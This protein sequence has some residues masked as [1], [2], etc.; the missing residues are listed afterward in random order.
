[1]L[2]EYCARYGVRSCFRHLCYLSDLLEH[3]ERGAMIDPTLIHY[4]FAFCSSHVHGHSAGAPP[5]G[6]VAF[7][8]RSDHGTVTVEERDLYASIKDRLRALLEYQIT[9]FRYCFP[10]GRPDGSLKATLSLLERVLMKDVLT[11]ASPDETRAVMK[12]CLENAALVN[13]TRLSDVAKIDEIAANA[14]MHP[15]DKLP[16]LVRLAE[17][18]VEL[19]QENNDHTE[20]FAWFSD[21][22]VEHCEIFWSLFAVDMDAIL[23]IQ[24]PDTWCSFPLFQVLN[25]YLRLDENM[26]GGRFH[27]HLRDTFAP[28]VVRYVDLMELSIAQSLHKGFERERWDVRRRMTPDDVTPCGDISAADKMSQLT[29]QQHAQGE[30]WEMKG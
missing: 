17:M 25:N 27:T 15:C 8:V 12:K 24:P 29:T 22:L 19:V 21:L 6:Q 30:R 28:Q 16:E 1:M 18:C 14:D 7:D 5:I 4:S 26:C 9:N 23:G 2:D 13:Y 11:P 10:F 20:A 3:A